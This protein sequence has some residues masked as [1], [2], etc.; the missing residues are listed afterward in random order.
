MVIRHSL[1]ALVF[2]IALGV[3][4]ACTPKEPAEK[5]CQVLNDCAAGETC[6]QGTCQKSSPDEN[7]GVTDAGAPSS[8]AGSTLDAGSILDGGPISDAGSP[9][10]GFVPADSGI[11]RDA[12]A[13]LAD[14]AA[15]Q[16]AGQSLESGNFIDAGQGLDAAASPTDAANA[17]SDAG[18]AV[19][20]SPDAALLDSGQPDAGPGDSGAGQ[21]VTGDAGSSD[22]GSQDSGLQDAGPPDG[23]PG[24]PVDVGCTHNGL[25]WHSVAH[26]QRVPL[27]V[28]Q[29]QVARDLNDFPLAITIPEVLSG[30]MGNKG[31]DLRAYAPDGTALPV[32]VDHWSD[33]DP[34][35]VWVKVDLSG[36]T[37]AV[38]ALLY[39]DLTA[40]ATGPPLATAVWSDGFEM[41]HHFSQGTSDYIEST[42]HGRDIPKNSIDMANRNTS[43]AAFGVAV[44]AHR[45]DFH[46]MHRTQSTSWAFTEGL[47]VEA[48]VKRSTD[49]NWAELVGVWMDGKDSYTGTNQSNH[50]LNPLTPTLTAD[51]NWH[52]LVGTFLAGNGGAPIMALYLDG[53][54]IASE[55]PGFTAIFPVQND[56]Y[57]SQLKNDTGHLDGF[58]DE[59][60]IANTARAPAWIKTQYR[61]MQ[62]QD[63]GFGDVAIRP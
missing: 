14:G 21:G 58:L 61:T 3:M 2:L 52:Y 55:D 25:V 50:A 33:T 15:L 13:R 26:A 37:K 35:N 6:V 62:G 39:F 41:V 32:E 45:T 49:G 23:G 43:D 11:D 48:W 5:S 31:A 42:T 12:G 60:R 44:E 19:G 34:P 38:A 4:A 24:Y 36:S 9:P 51:G 30:L 8:D 53:E 22:S 18:G 7:Q 17:Q 29:T 40:V 56:I 54:Q 57:F 10:D 28:D 46:Q 20:G 59:V 47:T 16:D 63:V 1:P 27:C